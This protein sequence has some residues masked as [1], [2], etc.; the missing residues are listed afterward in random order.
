M[1]CLVQAPLETVCFSILKFQVEKHETINPLKGKLCSVILSVKCSHHPP[2]RYLS[3][4]FKL[5]ERFATSIHLA[6]AKYTT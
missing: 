1:F 6:Y 4:I 2:K 5:S 3:R